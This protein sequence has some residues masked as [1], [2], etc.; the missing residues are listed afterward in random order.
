MNEG[1]V[2]AHTAATRR[3]R[4]VRASR[5][6]ASASRRYLP[7]LV[8]I[9]LV[10]LAAG[11]F[12][13]SY[14][15]SLA[16]PTPGSL[17]AGTVADE[18]V[19]PGFV[20]QLDRQIGTRLS[21][22]RY[23]SPYAAEQA[24]DTQRVFAVISDGGSPRAVGLEVVP[25]AGASI[26]RLLSGA[27]PAAARSAHMSLTVR[28]SHPLQPTD[29]EG[30][31][32]F[33]IT[34]AA[35]VVGFV[36]AIQLNA[37]AGGLRLGERF[38][39]IGCYA[40]LGAFA[41]AATVD[42]A[43]H[44]LSLPFA[45]SW[46]VLALTMATCGLIFTAFHAALGRWAILPIWL[47]LVLLGDPNSGGAA[48]TA[49]L[50]EPMR[51]LGR[52]LP[53]GASI[54]AQRTAIY[55]YGHQDATPFLILTAWGACAAGGRVGPAAA[56]PGASHN[57]TGPRRAPHPGGPVHA[58]VGPSGAMTISGSQAAFV[59]VRRKGWH[60]G[61]MDGRWGLAVRAFYRPARPGGPGR[62]LPGR[63]RHLD[64]PHRPR[65]RCSPGVQRA[66]GRQ[67]RAG[68]HRPAGARAVRSRRR[69]VPGAR[70]PRLQG[71]LARPVTGALSC[72]A[73]AIPGSCAAG[74]LGE[75][76]TDPAS[77]RL[78]L[79]AAPASGRGRGLRAARVAT[80][81]DL[82]LAVRLGQVG[83]SCCD[84]RLHAKSRGVELPPPLIGN[85]RQG[86]V[87]DHQVQ[88][89]PVGHCDPGSADPSRGRGPGG[90]GSLRQP[91]HPASV[92]ATRL[93]LRRRCQRKARSID[94]TAVPASWRSAF[95]VPVAAVILNWLAT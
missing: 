71:R 39:A 53:P 59:P 30:L 52:W 57:L 67:P 9:L 4:A 72:G 70:R 42:W 2:P 65:R 82:Q 81:V 40:A 38:I 17:A 5:R 84:S 8:I 13:G 37:Q 45:E 32:I 33:Y 55:F 12:A 28:Q 89:D 48:A 87:A 66:S 69:G 79:A 29:P 22:E 47:L 20:S 44:I 83:T 90:C 34:L 86:V 73:A 6:V 63:S 93:R 36:G 62:P 43:L 64:V 95:R 26:A 14:S 23:P 41:I 35:V 16:R 76:E 18:A 46:A 27:A 60:A 68:R 92:R 77:P 1:G 11:L 49:L 15:H 80:R 10:S 24:I 85:H 88:P 50:P 21:L 25:A 78:R 54:S 51:T 31:A 74:C 91:P 3:N 75:R 19:P 58:S 56:F 94:S 7:A 61:L